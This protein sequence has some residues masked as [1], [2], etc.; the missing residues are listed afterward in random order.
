MFT[1]TR[2]LCQVLESK[3]K[4]NA[5]WKLRKVP[6]LDCFKLPS[7]PIPRLHRCPQKPTKIYE[8]GDLS[9]PTTEYLEKYTNFENVI[10]SQ[11]IKS[12]QHEHQ[13]D[14]SKMSEC[15]SYDIIKKMASVKEEYKPKKK[16][17]DFASI[18][19]QDFKF[20]PLQPA[21]TMKPLER[22]LRKEGKMDTLPTY[23][24]HFRLW[25][26]EKRDPEKQL[27]TVKSTFQPLETLTSY[28]FSYRPH[29][30][31]P[32]FIK[33]K[34]VYK[35]NNEPFDDLTTNRQAYQGLPGEP[36]KIC[37][38]AI[39]RVAKNAQFGGNT[40]FQDNFHSWQIPLP[41][42]RKLTQNVPPSDHMKQSGKTHQ[43]S[44]PTQMTTGAPKKQGYSHIT[45][46]PFQG[47]STMKDDFKPWDNYC[48]RSLI[49]K[50]SYDFS[51]PS[52]KFEDLT[53]FRT[54]Y[55][56]HELIPTKSF[57]PVPLIV[58]SSEPFDD[59][60]LY[61]L[62]Y[63]AKKQETCPARYS[64]PPGYRFENTNFHGHK[65]FRKN[66][67]PVEDFTPSTNKVSN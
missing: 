48:R 4:K 63:T 58:N 27:P 21:K 7:N 35:P 41:K 22:S 56:E 59:T 49:I 20:Y 31:G 36:A 38:P 39:T 23:K 25:R 43:D 16:E 52:G 55:R 8:D 9:Y 46:F 24:D 62:H 64:P 50:P 32:K 45:K 53:T 42:I 37:L 30:L 6:I 54:H 51:S 14:G 10:P 5:T 44:I 11:N 18:Y 57:K 26:I 19:K 1:I 65:L 66:S 47:K 40:E 13:A 34:E 33:P 2:Q 28:L 17:I 3:P 29:G 67:P 15:L 12:L 61:S 60:T